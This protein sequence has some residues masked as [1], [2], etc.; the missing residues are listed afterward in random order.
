M[1]IEVVDENNKTD[2][3]NGEKV[4]SLNINQYDLKKLKVTELKNMAVQ[5]NLY[6][7]D[8][9]KKEK[10]KDIIDKLEQ[11]KINSVN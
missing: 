2:E 7:E 11:F 6:N 10:R 9:V 8:D 1:N 3:N 5:L 4:I